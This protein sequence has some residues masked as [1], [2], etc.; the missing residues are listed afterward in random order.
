[1]LLKKGEKMESISYG[2]KFQVD[3]NTEYADEGSTKLVRFRIQE[4]F[5]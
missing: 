2:I 3:M 1:M 5:V 4:L